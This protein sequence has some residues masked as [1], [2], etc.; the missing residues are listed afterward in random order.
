[1][2]HLTGED[3]Q[4]LI[5]HIHPDPLL[6]R[7]QKCRTH[8][9]WRTMKRSDC[10]RCR[11]TMERGRQVS[12]DGSRTEENGYSPRTEKI[13]SS[14]GPCQPS[15]DLGVIASVFDANRAFPI[16]L[17]PHIARVWSNSGPE[18]KPAV[19]LMDNCSVHMHDDT[20]KE[21]TAH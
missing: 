2:R 21:F 14:T 20:L 8:R 18:N 17:V 16:C 4:Q 1:M 12:R 15:A 13:A 19:F 6:L 7:G 9:K 5:C 3:S 10:V 11:Y